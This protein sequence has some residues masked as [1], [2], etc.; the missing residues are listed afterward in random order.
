MRW[1]EDMEVIGS[2]SDAGAGPDLSR[3]EAAGLTRSAVVAGLVV[4]LV[5]IVCF[6]IFFLFATRIWFS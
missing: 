2:R 4:A 3:R 5:Y 1:W 6:F